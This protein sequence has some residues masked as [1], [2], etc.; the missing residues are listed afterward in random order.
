MCTS[1]SLPVLR[2]ANAAFCFTRTSRSVD[3]F[4]PIPCVEVDTRV[5]GRVEAERLQEFEVL[6]ERAVDRFDDIG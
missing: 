2:P 3:R 4:V 1:L 6:V 5:R